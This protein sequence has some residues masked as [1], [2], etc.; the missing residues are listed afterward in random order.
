MDDVV[1]LG[2]P[3]GTLWCKYNLGAD[4]NKLKT[5]KQWYGDYYAWVE[6]ESKL[7]FNW[8]NYKYGKGYNKLTKYCTNS[9]KGLYGFTD[10]LTELLPEDDV[11]Y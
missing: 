4:S 5:A 2:L 11:A 6:I 10:N 9:I 1:D 3:S 8:D 7:R